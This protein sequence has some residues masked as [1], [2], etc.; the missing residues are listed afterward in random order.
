MSEHTPMSKQLLGAIVGATIALGLYETYEFATPH[1]QALLAPPLD[2]QQ[3]QGAD[4]GEQMEAQAEVVAHAKELLAASVPPSSIVAQVSSAASSTASSASTSS[5]SP[6]TREDPEYSRITAAKLREAERVRQQQ[7]ID[8][9]N[10][11]RA[12]SSSSS[13][14]HRL[15][16]APRQNPASTPA[17]SDL[18]DSG[19]GLWVAVIGAL[20]SALGMRYRRIAQAFAQR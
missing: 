4:H 1:V 2:V 6:R 12:R 9:A 20:G 16:P 7:A 15:P 18:P 19:I 8:A 5:S 10:A 11:A 3:E 13:S 14:R 17:A